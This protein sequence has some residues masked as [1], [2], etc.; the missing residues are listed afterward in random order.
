MLARTAKFTLLVAVLR[1]TKCSQ[2]ARSFKNSDVGPACARDRHS[3]P[4]DHAA[5]FRR[6]P[7]SLSI[8]VRVRELAH[9]VRK[10]VADPHARFGR[11]NSLAQCVRSHDGP[12]LI[13]NLPIPGVIRK[14][15][16]TGLTSGEKNPSEIMPQLKPPSHAKCPFRLRAP[17]DPSQSISEL[18]S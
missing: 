7:R 15:E 6:V 4:R 13:I 16:R 14:K 8:R 11:R 5:K 9:I 17:Q 18:R 10:E 1:A 3:G 12:R 2:H